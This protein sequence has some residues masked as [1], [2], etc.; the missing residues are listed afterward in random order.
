[1]R[2]NPAR[3]PADAGPAVRLGVQL[4]S[5]EPARSVSLL[6]GSRDGRVWQLSANGTLRREPLFVPPPLLPLSPRSLVATAGALA[7]HGALVAIAVGPT[8]HVLLTHATRARFAYR[9]CRAAAAGPVA[10]L[11][12]GSAPDAGSS[13]PAAAA[14]VSLAFDASSQRTL[15]AATAGGDVLLFRLQSRVAQ[16]QTEQQLQLQQPQHHEQRPQGN[17][18]AANELP[19]D[20]AIGPSQVFSAAD[21]AEVG[22]ASSAGPGC[23]RIQLLSIRGIVLAASLGGNA[24]EG[25]GGAITVHAFA[26][27]A[28][29]GI[30]LYSQTI[31][32]KGGS[33]GGGGCGSGSSDGCCVDDSNSGPGV[34][35]AALSTSA[36]AAAEGG[37]GRRRPQAGPSDGGAALLAIAT[38]PSGV[39]VFDCFAPAP[40]SAFGALYGGGGDDDGTMLGIVLAWLRSPL[41]LVAIAALSFYCASGRAGAG[42]GNEEEGGGGGEDE[43][44]GGSGRAA[45]LGAR[46]Q[47][48]ALACCASLLGRTPLG[49]ILQRQ[50]AMLAAQRTSST[51]GRRRR[52]AANV[53]LDSAAFRASWGPRAVRRSQWLAGIGGSGGDG[54]GGRR[55]GDGSDDSGG[56]GG[57]GGGSFG[58]SNGGFGKGGGVRGSSGGFGDGGGFG[59]G[60][61]AHDADEFD[62]DNFDAELPTNAAASN[63]ASALYRG[64]E[65]DA[66]NGGR[67]D[68]SDG[69]GDG[70][71]SAAGGDGDDFDD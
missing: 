23:R 69:G 36:A 40:A 56:G 43:D 53:D 66:F 24:G 27:N 16:P 45:G 50:S 35:L 55:G 41:V 39:L 14:I 46:W 60:G 9:P 3:L 15:W 22:G 6:A 1:L 12:G 57:L 68:D 2:P 54:G 70:G 19:G 31:P 61:F 65:G 34:L 37:R 20:G 17:A 25:S 64:G 28:S 33:G 10:T 4:A 38:S 13:S 44:D 32:A 71:D 42:H 11:A 30:K 59:G 51:A 47:R 8:V 26:S 7:R 62:A 5:D 58:G 49:A 29:A 48:S 21:L 18:G 67:A 63:A 52:I